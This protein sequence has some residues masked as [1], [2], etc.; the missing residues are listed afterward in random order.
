V[1]STTE[2]QSNNNTD[3]GFSLSPGRALSQVQIQMNRGR[4]RRV[5]AL[6]AFARRIALRGSGSLLE[7]GLA[8]RTSTTQVCEPTVARGA[9]C[10]RRRVCGERDWDWIHFQHDGTHRDCSAR[11]SWIVCVPRHNLV[12]AVA[13]I[14]ANTGSF[15]AADEFRSLHVLVFTAFM[16]QLARTGSTVFRV[17]FARWCDRTRTKSSQTIGALQGWTNDLNLQTTTPRKVQGTKCRS[18]R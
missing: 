10:T 13:A 2:Y 7:V 9:A 11:S 17:V 5:G 4:Y 15:P 12:A 8:I 16:H 1:L 6:D 14:A 3:T 18:P